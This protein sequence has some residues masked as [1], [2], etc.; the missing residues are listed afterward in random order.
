MFSVTG[1][2]GSCSFFGGIMSV[3]PGEIIDLRMAGRGAGRVD[4]P[5]PDPDQQGDEVAADDGKIIE[6]ATEDL[7]HPFSD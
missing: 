3:K 2:E 7:V 6:V 4:E 1:T 5:T